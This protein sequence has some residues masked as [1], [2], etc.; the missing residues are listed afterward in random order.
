MSDSDTPQSLKQWAASSTAKTKAFAKRRPGLSGAAAGIAATLL[1]LGSYTAAACSCVTPVFTTTTTTSTSTSTSTSTTS[2]TVPTTTIP[3]G[4]PTLFVSPSGSDSNN[5]TSSGTACRSLNGAYQKASQGSIVSVASGTY[6]NQVIGQRSDMRNLS[7]GCSISTPNQC[8]RFVT[9]G[10]VQI[11]GVIE[12]HG[13]NTWVD[14]GQSRGGPYGYNVTGYTDTE[15]DNESVHPD[16]VI[17]SGIDTT[18]F[19]VFNT[20]DSQYIDIDEGPATVSAGCGIIDG[21]GQ[22][23]NG[24]ESKIGSGGGILNPIPSNIL[25]DGLRIHDQNRDQAGADAGCHF[26]G[27]FMAGGNGITFRHTTWERNAVYNIQ[28]QS[29]GLP[30]SNIIFDHDSFGCAAGWLYNPPLVCD[31]QSSIQ[32]DQ[33][34]PGVVVQYSAFGEPSPAWGCYANCPVDYSTDTFG[35]GN[36]FSTGNTLV[37][38]PL[39]PG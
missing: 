9:G 25:I 33:T 5:C 4:T 23:V 16:H 31:N 11:N 28:L 2:T 18:S 13:S 1:A 38:P 36:T 20:V 32:F 19:G 37:A 17:L 3:A 26:G 22:G 12:D 34:V 6:G 35:P 27:I 8:V 39:I 30:V 21:N 7:P 10:G 15:A 24:I 14:G 29:I